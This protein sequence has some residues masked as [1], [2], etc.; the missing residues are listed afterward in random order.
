MF[1]GRSR[2]ETL[3]IYVVQIDGRISTVEGERTQVASRDKVLVLVGC[4]CLQSGT[5]E[6]GG[7]GLPRNS[8]MQRNPS[9]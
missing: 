7:E 4:H 5:I 9:E 2:D 1:D 6:I 3:S 8:D